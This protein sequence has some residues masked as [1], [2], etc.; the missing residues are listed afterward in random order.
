MFHFSGLT[1]HQVGHDPGSKIQKWASRGAGGRMANPKCDGPCGEHA[2]NRVGSE[3][4]V[5]VGVSW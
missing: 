3:V 5:R 2:G 4:L 1:N